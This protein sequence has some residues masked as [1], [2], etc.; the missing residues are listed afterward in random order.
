MCGLQTR[1]GRYNPHVVGEPQDPWW[2]AAGRLRVGGPTIL[3]VFVASVAGL[4]AGCPS[5]PIAGAACH[6]PD[7]LVCA[8]GDRALLCDSAS[9]RDVPCRGRR[10]CNQREG[11]DECD[12]ELALEGDPCPRN[13][14]VDYACSVDHTAALECR[15]GRFSLWRRCRG[16]AGCRLVADHRLD[17]DTTLSEADDPCETQGTYSCSIDRTAMLQCNG[18]SF[19]AA[20]SCRG[21]Q[22]C[23]LDPDTHKVACADTVALEGDPCDEERRITCNMDGKAELICEGN[24]YLRKRECRHMGC[25]VE[26][27][28][29]F[30]D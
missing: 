1:A 19:V 15:S 16:E 2:K 24:R 25:R 11:A 30:C 18:R 27:S 10:G 7:R 29:L 23:R 17:C 14:A 5:R 22:G 12:D 3:L 28:E 13:P 9:W 6:V 21:P 4:M 20:S 8:G 26:G